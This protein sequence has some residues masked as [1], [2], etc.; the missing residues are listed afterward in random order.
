[1]L[2]ADKITDE[3]ARDVLAECER[4]IRRGEAKQGDRDLAAACRQ[5]VYAADVRDGGR[6]RVAEILNARAK[7]GVG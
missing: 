6:N 2:T 7:A 3:M 4:R 1:M 5:A